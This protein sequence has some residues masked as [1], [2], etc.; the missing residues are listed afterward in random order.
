MQQ[1]VRLSHGHRPKRPSRQRPCRQPF[2]VPAPDLGLAYL[3]DRPFAESWE[4]M[5]FE[6]PPVQLVSARSEYLIPDQPS[7]IYLEK[8]FAEIRVDPFRSEEHT[9]ELQS[10]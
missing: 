5:I 4:Q 8:D 9:S 6:Q 10:L 7:R 2:L 3:S 1:P